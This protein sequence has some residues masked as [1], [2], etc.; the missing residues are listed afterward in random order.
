MIYNVSEQ[1]ILLVLLSLDQILN[2]TYTALPQTSRNK[3]TVIKF[4]V[5]A[6]IF[7]IGGA[8]CIINNLGGWSIM[9]VVNYTCVREAKQNKS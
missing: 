8:L 5:L 2:N 7:A 3:S 4:R 9:G 1:K 6:R